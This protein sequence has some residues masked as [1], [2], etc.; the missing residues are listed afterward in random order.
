MGARVD[1]QKRQNLVRLPLKGDLL[2]VKKKRKKN[3]ST[4]YLSRDD[5]IYIILCVRMRK[6]RN[7]LELICNGD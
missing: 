5:I 2:Q 7:K 4:F 1:F 3:S 6:Q